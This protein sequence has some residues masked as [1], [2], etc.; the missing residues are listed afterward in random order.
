[1][2]YYGISD[3]PEILSQLLFAKNQ[4]I[5]SL[6]LQAGREEAFRV[7]IDDNWFRILSEVCP[8][9]RL[10]GHT[11]IGTMVEHYLQGLSV[12]GSADIRQEMVEH[13]HEPRNLILA[14]LM[15]ADVVPARPRHSFSPL[16]LIGARATQLVTVC[17]NHPSW[18]ACRAT[19]NA[20]L[21]WSQSPDRETSEFPLENFFGGKSIISYTIDD[22]QHEILYG[23]LV[24]FNFQ[25]LS[26]DNDL[27]TIFA[28]DHTEQAFEA[29]LQILDKYI[30]TREEGR[31]SH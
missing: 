15:L 26:L 7:F 2:Y 14:F 21:S 19:I 20:L 5:L 17:P 9:A 30:V 4:T 23:D 25:S 31:P 1:M 22:R 8:P 3:D 18:T 29:A 24:E 11:E 6:S 13:L 28:A 12:M 27:R 16:S 10:V